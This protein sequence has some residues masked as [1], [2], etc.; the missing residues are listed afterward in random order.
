MP[1]ASELLMKWCLGQQTKAQK[2]KNAN[3][4]SNV[5]PLIRSRSVLSAN[6][7]VKLGGSNTVLRSRAK[8]VFG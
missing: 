8:D 2:E 7:L 5:R 4:Y 6:F 1:Y 3:Y